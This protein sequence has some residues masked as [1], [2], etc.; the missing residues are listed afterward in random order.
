[1]FLCGETK[2]RGAERTFQY[3]RIPGCTIG[4]GSVRYLWCGALLQFWLS[5]LAFRFTAEVH[6]F[7]TFLH[8]TSPGAAHL[9]ECPGSR[10]GRGGKK[11]ALKTANGLRKQLQSHR[12]F[13]LIRSTASNASIYAKFF[14][15]ISQVCVTEIL[16]P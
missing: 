6:K 14:L 3:R 8:L 10:H 2:S 4:I 12:F 7:S 9:L 5:H 1:M 15:P 16:P 13:N 11:S